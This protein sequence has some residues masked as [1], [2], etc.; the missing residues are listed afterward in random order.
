MA[1]LLVILFI[2]ALSRRRLTGWDYGTPFVLA[3]VS[4]W[5]GLA[6]VREEWP[7]WPIHRVR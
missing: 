6:W 2:A 4:Q 7:P 3:G 5:V 1:A